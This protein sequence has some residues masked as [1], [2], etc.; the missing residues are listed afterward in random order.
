[1]L[2][3]GGLNATV[4]DMARWDRALREHVVLSA[5]GLA[6]LWKPV[7][8]ADGSVFRLDGELLGH[9]LGWST[10]GNTV[11]HHRYLDDD[12][13]VIVLTNC[14]GASPNALAEGVAGF[15]VPELRERPVFLAEPPAG[16]HL[17]SFFARLEALLAG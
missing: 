13:A 1:M 3:A 15:Y 7:T 6:E 10:A 9:A 14:Q 4:E 16:V 5:Q 11:A 12:L 2:S 8:L 17:A